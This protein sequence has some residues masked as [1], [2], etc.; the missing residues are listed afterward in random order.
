MPFVFALLSHTVE[1]GSYQLN[2]ASYFYGEVS[3]TVLEP[4]THGVTLL[5]VIQ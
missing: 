1:P 2:T 4:L 3:L 5:H